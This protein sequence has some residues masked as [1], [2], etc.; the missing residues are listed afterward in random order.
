M[1]REVGAAP[2]PTPED[3][4]RAEHMLRCSRDA[5]TIVGSDDAA[6]VARDMVRT[7]ALVNCFTEIGEAAARLTPRGRALV[8]GFP[9][10]Q[11]VGMRNIV[12]H[13]YWGIDVG[14]LVAS[15]HGDLPD[16][17]ASLEAALASWPEP[18]ATP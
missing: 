12:V 6:S 7:R 1:P 8:G 9:W 15:V 10:R 2:G 16:L 14:A 4:K 18:P 17:I 13:V 11:I 3:R 5:R